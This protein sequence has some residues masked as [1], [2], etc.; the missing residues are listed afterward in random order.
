MSPST[1]IAKNFMEKWDQLLPQERRQ[2]FYKDVVEMHVAVMQSATDNLA[3]ALGR[4]SVD[5]TSGSSKEAK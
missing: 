3:A 5:L 2:E 4:P 1:L